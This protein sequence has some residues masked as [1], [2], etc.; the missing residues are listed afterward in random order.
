MKKSDLMVQEVE[1]LCEN[2]VLVD[3]A[4]FENLVIMLTMNYQL[5]V[6]SESLLEM[7][8]ARTD[9]ELQEYLIKHVAEE[10]GHA[11]WLDE[12]LTS[13][14]IDVTKAPLVAG[15]VEVVGAQYY[16][17]LHGDPATIL[18]YL[19]VM[20][21]FPMDVEFVEKLA[22]VHGEKVLR[23]LKYHAIHDREHRLELFDIID[24]LENTS[25]INNAIRCQSVLNN[26]L[27]QLIPESSKLFDESVKQWV[28]DRTDCEI[29]DKTTA[30]GSLNN[31]GDIIAGVVYNHYTG[32]S[33][34]STFA[35]ADKKGL[36]KR[37]VKEIF[38]YP[39]EQL[40]VNKIINYVAESN[41]ESQKITEKFGFCHE[42]TIE[43]V[44]PDGAMRVYS[45]LKEDCKWLDA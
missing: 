18:G 42:T 29:G 1:N 31:Q 14:G 11:K 40:G 32:E 27:G 26:I 21:A 44:Y 5:M 19:F 34:S 9:G 36:S 39:F 45:L 30:I 10:R 17:I 23:T 6:A 12:D 3:Y 8:I 25:M 20:E 33:I 43:G 7:A 35:V 13:V 16:H 22:E 24:K 37:F 2:V 15:L 4:N 38:K 41:I 28:A